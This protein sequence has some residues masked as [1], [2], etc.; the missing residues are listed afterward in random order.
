MIDQLQGEGALTDTFILKSEYGRSELNRDRPDEKAVLD[1][2]EPRVSK[3]LVD[4]GMAVEYPDNKKFA[5]CL[6]HDV[7]DIYPPITHAALE[8]ACHSKSLNAKGLARDI[9]W[10]ARGKKASPYRNFKQIM[11]IEEKFGAVS[12]FYFMATDRDVKRFRYH[13][14]DLDG[15]LGMIAD[16]G[17]EVGLHGGYY[18]YD[19]LEALKREKARLEK[20][21]GRKTIGYRNHYLRFNVPRTWELLSASG[22]KYDTTVGY[23][24]IVGFRNGMCH[25][26]RPC[27]PGNMRSLDILEIPMAIMDSSLFDQART[28]DEAWSLA[29]QLVDVTER[30]GGVLTLLWHNDAFGVSFRDNWVKIYK[31]ILNYSK[32]KNAW[33]TSGENIYQWWDTHGR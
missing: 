22:F 6:T 28:L 3:Y 33:I 8:A 5:V 17:W 31:R 7:D 19:D 24:N 1:A 2:L 15:E 27:D 23:N 29:K 10:R 21:F 13:I 4:R 32:D 20:V 30:Y 11:D 16:R 18:A 9:F 25:P 12:S 26:Y 14:E